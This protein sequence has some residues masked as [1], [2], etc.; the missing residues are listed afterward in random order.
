MNS[1]SMSVV[2]QRVIVAKDYGHMHMLDDET[3]GLRGNLTY[4]VAKNGKERKPMRLFTGGIMVAFLMAYLEK[5][6]GYF[7]AIKDDPGV[8]PVEFS[9][10]SFLV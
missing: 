10:Y 5:K 3:K 9:T 6:K 8:A 1:F 7:M 2:H 4:C